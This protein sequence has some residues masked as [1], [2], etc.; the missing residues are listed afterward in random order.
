[1][2]TSTATHYNK[3]EVQDLLDKM[4]ELDFARLLVIYRTLGCTA[5]S[6]LSEEDVLGQV[7]EKTLSLNR[8]WPIDVK[9]INFLVETGKSVVSNEEEKYSKFNINPSVDELLAVKDNSLISTSATTKLSHAPAETEIE[10]YQSENLINT[11]I[12]KI[13]KLFEGDSGAG[14]FIRQK[15]ESQEKSRI[16]VLC[17]FTDQVYRNVEK[18]VKDKLRKRFPNGFPW[19]EIDS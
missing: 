6:G 8:R 14:C 17:E 15:L 5:R 7:I 4:T 2:D 10:H 3:I 13:Q 16:L 9:T 19:W 12:Q 1:M 18:R 11:W